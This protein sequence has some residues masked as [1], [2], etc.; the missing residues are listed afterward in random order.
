[1][2]PKIMNVNRKVTNNKEKVLKA[3][4]WKTFSLGWGIAGT[5]LLFAFVFIL[6]IADRGFGPTISV[7]A[8]SIPLEVVIGA[9]ASVTLGFHPVVGALVSGI[10]HLALAPILITGFDFI[11]RKWGWLRRK[12]KKAEEISGKYGKYG[13]WILTPLAPIIGV[14][15]SI[16][17]GVCLRF[18]P[19]LV[20]A[21]VSI[22]TL[23]VAF[24]VT[25]GGAGIVRLLEL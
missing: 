25:L 22:G 24:L 5:A 18:R 21:S 13:V 8:A 9:T 4:K 3:R 16:A 2:K 11:V 12:L 17:V 7:V 1:M 19:T 15:V 6:G 23:I 14:F 20:M 10:A